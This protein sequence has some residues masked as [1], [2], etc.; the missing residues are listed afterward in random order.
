MEEGRRYLLILPGIAFD[1][2]RNRL[3]YGGGYYD[4]F[5]EKYAGYDIYKLMLAYELEKVDKLPVE[6]Y[7]IPSDKVITEVNVY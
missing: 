6:S 2:N 5:L 7:D 1:E 3:G 4:R